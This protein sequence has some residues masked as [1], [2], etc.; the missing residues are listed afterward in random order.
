METRLIQIPSHPICCSISAGGI[1]GVG[2]YSI[3]RG[4]QEEAAEC[5][6]RV[7]KALEDP[8]HLV[9]VES[10]NWPLVEHLPGSSKCLADVKTRAGP[11]IEGFLVHPPSVADPPAI[12]VKR[13][14]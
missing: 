13:N 9:I 3:F 11:A 8:A 10:N 2:Y 7:L 14:C 6:R 4:K 12:L 1:K 5:L